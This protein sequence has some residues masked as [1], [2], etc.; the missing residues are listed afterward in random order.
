MIVAFMLEFINDQEKIGKC[1][2]KLVGKG[3]GTGGGGGLTEPHDPRL[4]SSSRGAEP[5]CTCIWETVSYLGG[6]L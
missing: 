6:C 4:P 1:L 3:R 2:K 5:T